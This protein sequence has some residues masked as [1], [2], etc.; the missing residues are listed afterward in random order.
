V[1][2]WIGLSNIFEQDSSATHVVFLDTERLLS[3]VTLRWGAAPRLEVGGRITVETTGGG[4]LD[5]FVH[6]YHE[7]LSFGQANRD[8]FPQG[9]YA[10]RVTDGGDAP[11]VDLR[12]R[13]MGL[14]DV[15][16]FAK[17]SAHASPDGRS[18]LSVRLSTRVPTR[19]N[20]AAPEKVDAALSVL[21]RSGTGPWYFHAMVSGVLVRA[22]PELDPVLRDGVAFFG[23]AVERSLGP[24]L[25]A[26]VQYQVAT[27]M[28]L[29]FGH[30]E[31]DGPAGNL[32]A[33]AAG[34]WGE[35]WSWNASFQEDLPADTPAID[36]T[37][38]LSV[39]RRWR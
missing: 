1:H 21:G 12:R 19:G 30:R 20:R 35:T 31:L 5:G 24:D 39:S 11:F 32:V 34:R 17:W 9:G 37:L 18:A 29:G 36:F 26:V 23:V 10:Q 6:W 3:A 38:G 4:V 15:Q 8:R 2:A 13:T 28:L 33:G 27:P 22:A 7:A 25:A 14:A 16:L